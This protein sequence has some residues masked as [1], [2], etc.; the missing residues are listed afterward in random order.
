LGRE[1]AVP[2]R[3]AVASPAPIGF[4]LRVGLESIRT[5]WNSPRADSGIPD[6]KRRRAD[7]GGSLVEIGVHL[8]D[9]WRYLLGTEVEEV[10]ALRF[11]AATLVSS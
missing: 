11:A 8:F 1:D 3:R 7:G 10:F 2:L 9:L 4:L 6:W 5:I